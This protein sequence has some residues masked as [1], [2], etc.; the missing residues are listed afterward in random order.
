MEHT[1]TAEVAGRPT[2]TRNFPQRILD[3]KVRTV[4]AGC[5]NGWMSELEGRAKP[6]L[7][8]GLSGR[9]RTL[10]RGGQATL[11]AWAFKTALVQ[12][13]LFRDVTIGIPRRH[14]DELR[15]LQAAPSDVAIWLAAY[16]GPNPVSFRV[17]GMAISRP[18]DRVTDEDD[19]NLYV[20]TFTVGPW[21]FQVFGV[22]D[23]AINIDPTTTRT[24]GSHIR[25]IAPF[26]RPFT[27]SPR[28]GLGDADLIRF[29]ES[30]YRDLWNQVD[31]T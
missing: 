30:I 19:P 28:V 12:A 29:S 25:R 11:A 26:D 7:L 22:A 3:Q 16:V 9:G 17:A 15:E 5:N 31:R 4:C 24:G 13:E 14:Y 18:G 27:W 2:D 23:P 20:I 10:N 6:L 21:L 8:A 1:V